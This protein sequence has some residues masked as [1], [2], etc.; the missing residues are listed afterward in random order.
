MLFA[1]SQ[2]TRGRPVSQRAERVTSHFVG[3]FS[4]G[5]GQLHIPD[6]S[7]DVP[8]SMVR[9]SGEARVQRDVLVWG[10]TA[11]AGAK[12]VP[13]AESVDGSESGSKSVTYGSDRCR[14]SDEIVIE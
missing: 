3:R 10:T 8:G 9:L 11:I 13:A 7:F 4:L 6:V 12:D 2:R 5:R 14:E 1:L